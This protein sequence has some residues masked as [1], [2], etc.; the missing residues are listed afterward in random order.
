M[1]KQQY[2][3]R[4]YAVTFIFSTVLLS[5]IV[6]TQNCQS[7]ISISLHNIKG[8]VYGNQLV[9]L[10]SLSDGKS[11]TE[12]SNA[13]GEVSLT[14]PCE[15]LFDVKI[16]NYTSKE[17][18]M[19]PKSGTVSFGLEY[20]PNMA[21]KDAIFAMNSSEMI[22]V[23]N[24]MKSLPD[25]SYIQKTNPPTPSTS[26]NYSEFRITLQDLKNKPLVG[27]LVIITGEKRNKS[28]KGKTNAMGELTAYLPKGDLYAIHFLYHKNYIKEE[29][30]YQKGTSK[31]YLNLTYMGAVE[32]LRRK[33]IEDERL[34]QER[35]IALMRKEELGTN[36]IVT[37][38]LSRNKWVDKLFVCDL[39]Y[40]MLPFATELAV[41][42]KLNQE[43]EKTTQ[44]AFF[45]NGDKRAG[46]AS[47]TVYY[48]LSEGYTNLMNLVKKVH[49]RNA[50]LKSENDVVSLVKSSN[51]VQTYKDI[52][53]LVDKDAPL[54]D[55]EYFL[56]FK[57]PVHIILCIEPRSVNPQH[58]KIAWKTKG[59][60]H[61]SK[62]DI[63]NIGRLVEGNT[64]TIEG[65]VYK[66]MGGEFVS[67]R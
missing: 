9:E 32:Y 65:V 36:E 42:Y 22:L 11:Y 16:S 26:T 30:K 54:V 21:E 64:I 25:T 44:F 48:S 29:I 52:V 51:E 7:V 38:V 35:K 28:F 49:T 4:F 1:M 17:Q 67:I 55:T 10:T 20:E 45:F 62:E 46:H 6:F 15:Q 23:D 12:I 3:L 63:V 66:I 40:E 27:E 24:L 39:S 50:E 41:W 43:K 14:V 19:S 61:T 2:A 8:G 18:V 60:F 34:E 13:K 47:S 33:K 59:S 5:N 58:L 53:M 31:G 56:N 37:K 57:K